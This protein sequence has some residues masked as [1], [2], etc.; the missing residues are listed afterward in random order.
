MFNTMI[1]KNEQ[2]PAVEE[3]KVDNLFSEIIFEE[4]DGLDF[5]D[6]YCLKNKIVI[7]RVDHLEGN[8]FGGAIKRVGLFLKDGKQLHKRE[9]FHNETRETPLPYE[10]LVFVGRDIF[11]IEKREDE[12]LHVLRM[13]D[14]VVFGAL[15]EANSSVDGNLIYMVF[16]YDQ[17]AKYSYHAVTTDG[18][19][20]S[21]FYTVV[22]NITN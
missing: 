1:K 5:L 21:L 20:A 16:L 19:A 14:V 7:Q 2:K 10:Y 17:E 9:F 12:N 15:V 8:G 6:R 22:N 18:S 4:M 11:V 13:A 3:K